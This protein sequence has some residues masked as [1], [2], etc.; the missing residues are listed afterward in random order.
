MKRFYRLYVFSLV[1]LSLLVLEVGA[2]FLHPQDKFAWH[3]SE[4]RYLQISDGFPDFEIHKKSLIEVTKAGYTY[5]P[6]HLYAIAPI[7]TETANFTDYYSSRLVPESVPLEDADEVVWFFGGSTMQD[8]GAPDKLTIANA[9]AKRLRKNGI[10][11]HVRNFGV[12]G[13]QSSLELTKFTELLRQVPKEEQPT[14]VFFYDGFNDAGFGFDVRPGLYQED[15]SEKIKDLV[16]HKFGRLSLYMLSESLAAYS[17]FWK[18]YLHPHIIGKLYKHQITEGMDYQESLEKAIS[19]YIQNVLMTK[20]VCEVHNIK[21]RFILQ[22]MIFTKKNLTSFEQEVLSI[23]PALRVAFFK[24][25]YMQAKAV[26]QSFPEFIDLT[27]VF[28][29]SKYADFYDI[30]HVSPASGAK[31]GDFLARYLIHAM[32]SQ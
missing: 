32:K 19:I 8:L 11:P 18:A 13:F 22:P 9:F 14:W 2:R 5:Y 28:D 27:T 30:G 10:N 16:G 24:D 3:V 6:Y 20:A 1:L 25:F 12:G 21:C 7:K 4:P 31:I 23:E 26:L 29:N 17:V 15:I